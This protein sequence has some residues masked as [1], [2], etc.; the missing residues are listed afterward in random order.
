MMREQARGV[1]RWILA[2][3]MLT[4][5]LPAVAMDTARM[6]VEARLAAAEQA[7]AKADAA[8]GEWRDTGKLLK[9]AQAALAAG[10]HQK[11]LALA[12]VVEFQGEQGYQQTLGQQN[13]SFPDIMR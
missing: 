10:D 6:A 5:T 12:E 3:T 13:L 2:A 4:A 8:G 11:A 1:G 7:R 9:Q